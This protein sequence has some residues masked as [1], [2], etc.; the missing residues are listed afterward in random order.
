MLSRSICMS[1]KSPGLDIVTD[2]DAH[3]DSDV[4]GQSWTNYPP[5]AH[6]RL[7]S[8]PAADPGRSGRAWHFHPATS[9]MTLIPTSRAMPSISGPVT[10]GDLQDAAMWKVA[11]RLTRK[12]VKFGTIGPELVAFAVQDRHYKSLKDRILAVDRR[13][14]RGS[15][16]NSPM[17]AVRSSSSRSRRFI[18]W[19]CATSS[20]T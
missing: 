17:P 7:R 8:Q 18:C 11:Q 14:K 19:R 1:R 12:P 2:G 6:G 5:R 20:M 3:F 15:C 10:L 16:T 13:I 9:C 4:G